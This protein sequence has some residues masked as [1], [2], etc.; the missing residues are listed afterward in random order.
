M[1]TVTLDTSEIDQYLGKPVDNSPLRKPIGNNDI[2]RWIRAMHHP[3]LSHN[4]SAFAAASRW[5]GLVAPQ[6]FPIVTDN[7]HGAAPV[8][9]GR[10][11]DSFTASAAESDAGTIPAGRPPNSRRSPQV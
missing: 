9:V 7:G 6:S 8:C 10:I 2:R 4:D 11:P 3:S 1:T 5:G